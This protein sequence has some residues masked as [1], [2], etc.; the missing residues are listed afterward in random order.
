MFKCYKSNNK[1]LIY[2]L[3]TIT[4]LINGFASSFENQINNYVYSEDLISIFSSSPKL[5]MNQDGNFLLSGENKIN[6]VKEIK[7]GPDTDTHLFICLM[8]NDSSIPEFSKGS[9]FE[10]DSSKYEN[11]CAKNAGNYTLIGHIY[12]P[13]VKGTLMEKPN[14]K[15]FDASPN[16]MKTDISYNEKYSK[17]SDGHN[18]YSLIPSLSS[19]LK[20]YS[21]LSMEPTVDHI[22]YLKVV[23]CT[24]GSQ[25]WIQEWDKNGESDGP[26]GNLA[27]ECNDIRFSLGKE[28]FVISEPYVN[29]NLWNLCTM[30]RMYGIR[31]NNKKLIKQA[32]FIIS[33]Y[34]LT[35]ENPWGNISENEYKTKF[36][37][38]LKSLTGK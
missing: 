33:K 37:T 4:F 26:H 24:G 38:A 7:Y 14:K 34:S 10:L 25:Y 36:E 18:I 30:I 27:L 6:N 9:W 3:C 20:E 11:Y 5:Y 12:S 23:S 15:S 32:E 1:Y 13:D 19:D 22:M 28:P 29:K 31:V 16:R 2:L 17:L 35:A 21:I 8:K